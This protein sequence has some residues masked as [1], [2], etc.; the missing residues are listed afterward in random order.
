LA[1]YAALREIEGEDDFVSPGTVPQ[2]RVEDRVIGSADADGN[3]AD[4]C[5]VEW[6]TKLRVKLATFLIRVG[7]RNLD[8]SVLQQIHP[9][10]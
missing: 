3:F 8:A 9:D 4:I 2:E 10:H 7:I 1:L 5:G 6:I